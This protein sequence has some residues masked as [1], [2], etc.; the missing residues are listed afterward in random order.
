MTAR[1]EKTPKRR[2]TPIGPRVPGEAVWSERWAGIFFRECRPV[3][4]V[5]FVVVDLVGA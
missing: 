1:T 5:A 2:R 3:V 4:E